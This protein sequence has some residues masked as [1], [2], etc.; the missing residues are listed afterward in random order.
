MLKFVRW[1]GEKCLF[2]NSHQGSGN[3]QDENSETTISNKK[4]CTNVSLVSFFA[5]NTN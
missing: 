3:A 5:D 2:G 1:Q 4:E